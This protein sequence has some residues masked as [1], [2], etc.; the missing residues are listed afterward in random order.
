MVRSSTHIYTTYSKKTSLHLS[1]FQITE[2]SLTAKWI[3]SEANESDSLQNVL[4][5]DGSP[6]SE[7]I[8]LLLLYHTVAIDNFLS[9]GTNYRFQYFM[10]DLKSPHI[11][12]SYHEGPVN[13]RKGYLSDG[14]NRLVDMI[15]RELNAK[16]FSTGQR[17]VWEVMVRAVKSSF[18][19]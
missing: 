10:M 3:T 12:Q 16:L 14:S 17:F 15:E 4:I 11:R 8:G 13:A 18:I 2:S 6:A 9:S 5:K 19:M 1:Y 7:N